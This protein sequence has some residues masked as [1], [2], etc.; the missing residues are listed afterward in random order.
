MTQL[1]VFLTRAGEARHQA[2]QTELPNVRQRCL[3]AAEAWEAMADREEK[4]QSARATRD[5]AK[6]AESTDSD[7]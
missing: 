4:L 6:Q 7:A 1:E 5:R 2:G 3:R